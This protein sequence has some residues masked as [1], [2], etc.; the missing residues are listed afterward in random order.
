ME[1]ELRLKVRQLIE[2]NLVVL[3]ECVE[4]ADSDNIFAKGFVNSLFAMKLLT[5]VEG[6]LGVEFDDDDLDL[7]NFNS[8]DNIVKLAERKLQLT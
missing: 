7:S 2:K 6:Q 8:I 1:A 3:D 5:F 4:F